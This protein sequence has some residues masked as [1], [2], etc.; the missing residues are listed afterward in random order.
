MKT[1][2]F[3]SDKPTQSILLDNSDYLHCMH[4]KLNISVSYF[5]LSLSFSVTPL[6]HIEYNYKMGIKLLKN[7]TQFS[8]K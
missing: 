7:K 5:F 1:Y 6:F 8:E 3:L 4:L 2:T